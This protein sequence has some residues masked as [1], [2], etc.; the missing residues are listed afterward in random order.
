MANREAGPT[1]T[2]NPRGWMRA[3]LRPLGLSAAGLG[4][5]AA[6]F[7]VGRSSAPVALPLAPQTVAQSYAES[8]SISALVQSTPNDPRELIP[9]PG[10]PGE[11]QPGGEECPIYL[12]QD[13][14]L[15]ELPPGSQPGGT[16]PGGGSPE[17][18]PLRPRPGTPRRSPGQ[19]RTPPPSGGFT[20][21][22]RPNDT[23]VLH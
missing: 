16:E 3:A 10:R 11:G 23:L 14:E 19:P 2:L 4:L 9:L 13:G 12:F 22:P 6:G 15:F 8:H 20:D 17:L 5:L 18:F 1:A 7:F 21:A